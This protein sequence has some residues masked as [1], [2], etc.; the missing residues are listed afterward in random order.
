MDADF[1]SAKIK[2]VSANVLALDSRDVA[3]ELGRAGA[4]RTLRLDRQWHAQHIQVIGV[5][6]AR[7]EQGVYHAEHYEIFAGGSHIAQGPHYGC[8]LWLHREEPFFQRADGLSLRLVDFQVTVRHA[9]PRRLFVHCFDRA[10]SL[11]FVVLHAPCLGRPKP[12]CPRPLQLI[13]DWW[14]DTACLVKQHVTSQ[15]AWVMVDANAPLASH[16]C[17]HFDLFDADPS[18]PQGEAFEQFIVESRRFAPASFSSLHEGAGPSHG[19]IRN[20]HAVGKTMCLSP[21]QYLLWHC[22]PVF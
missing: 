13:L 10:V 19:D 6:E 2:V 14:T 1:A 7:A 21:G 11:N 4:A 16:A 12:D 3:R 18:N 15:F 22:N 20:V 5:Q 9:D 17:L 8:E